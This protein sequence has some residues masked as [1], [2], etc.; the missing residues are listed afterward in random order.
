MF[1]VLVAL[2]VAKTASH[3]GQL[4]GIM[5][6]VVTRVESLIED[7]ADDVIGL[8][9]KFEGFK[10]PRCQLLAVSWFIVGEA[11]LTLRDEKAEIVKEL[12]GNKRWEKLDFPESVINSMASA[13]FK[14][15]VRYIDEGKETEVEEL[16]A[17]LRHQRTSS[18]HIEVQERT[19]IYCNLLD[20]KPSASNLKDFQTP[21]QPVHPE[22]QALLAVPD[23]LMTPI[24][25]NE[26]ELLTRKDDGSIE[27]HY[28][29][30]DEMA[31]HEDLSREAKA[32]LKQKSMDPFYLKNSKP[33]KK[34]RKSDEATSDELRSESSPVEEQ[35]SGDRVQQLPV[36][37][38]TR[39][40]RVNRG[41]ALPT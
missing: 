41:S 39:T 34:K 6:D 17:Y 27:Y 23:L 5:L 18:K 29:R 36:A 3:E 8:L 25:I 11:S 4:S 22:A 9:E 20:A 31:S 40:Y 26:T 24:N 30:D 33:R 19:T 7:I 16:T 21:L 1:E 35:K 15:T 37:N 14:L 12:L 10:S 2:A 32:R 13:A 28:F 38:P